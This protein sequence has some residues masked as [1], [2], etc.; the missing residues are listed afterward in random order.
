MS[1][2]GA[3]N[4][5]E[6]SYLVSLE[7]I[8][9]KKFNIDPGSTIIWN[10]DPLDADISIN[11]RYSVRASPFDL[12]ADQISGLSDVDK[13][14]YKQRYPFLVLLKL[15]GE[16][17]HPEISF[18]IQLS[19][20]DKGILG[21]AVNQKLIMLNE[22]PSAL[23][24]QVF[25]LLVLGRFVQEN[26]FQTETG[27]TA[28]LI[29]STVGKFLSVQL[30]QLSSKVLPGV[31][32]NFDIQSYDD[33]QTGQAVGRTQVEIGV[34]KQLFNERLS[35]QLGGTLDVEGD[36]TK[37]NSASDITSDVTIEYKLTEDGRFRMK[38]FR[39]NQYEGAIEGQLVE[40][41][42]GVI[43]VR[44]FNKWKEF[45]FSPKSKSDPL[46]KTKK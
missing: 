17:L 25:A 28:T 7:S 9:K 39:H 4:L 14:G 26:P 46:Q 12:V 31:D 36:M 35:I 15:R 19:P 20:E 16:I 42:A 8:I 11:A 23:N 5:S 38:G 1:L 41:G 13:G 43:Y 29:R 33:Y 37:Q 34:K 24:K 40:T 18:E 32:L 44:D 30:N 6:G 22:D 21:G 45:F 3:Y 27:G 10:G 2:T